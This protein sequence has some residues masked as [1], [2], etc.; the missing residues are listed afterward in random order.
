[1]S[2]QALI[3]K[4]LKTAEKE[5]EEITDEILARAGENEMLA[6][7]NAEAECAAIAKASGEKCAQIKRIAELTS[8]LEARKAKLHA[9][10]EMLDE[11]FA[12]A[13]RKMKRADQ[14]SRLSFIEKLIGKFAPDAEMTAVVS[15]KDYEA[16]SA[17]K[18]A[19]EQD[20]CK[21]FG[22][23]AK[24]KIEQSEKLAGGV[25]MRSELCD[26][27]ASLDAVFADLREKYEAEADKLLFPEL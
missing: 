11:A 20:L 7:K 9:R 12:A 1:M 22:K 8:G 15:D 16:V 13:Y 2:Q 5:A 14:S 3:D 6:I 27:D 24:L 18:A 10:R 19:I 25:Y 26:V 23:A 21:K 17:E 4:I